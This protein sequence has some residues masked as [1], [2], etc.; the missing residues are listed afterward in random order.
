[1]PVCRFEKDWTYRGLPCL[2]IENSYLRVLLFPQLGGHI[3]R[4]VDK[5]RDRNVLWESPRVRLH[6]TELHSNFDDHWSG[7]W[8][9]IFPNGMPMTNSSGDALPGMGELWN[10]EC[11]WQVVEASKQRVEVMLRMRTPISAVEVQRS[12]AVSV[13]EPVV[14]VSYRLSN[15][16]ASPV[17]YL[18][19]VH[20]ALDVTTAHRFDIP[21][22]HAEVGGESSGVPLGTPGETYRWPLLHGTDLSRPLPWQS[23]SYALHYLT[24]LTEGWAA[25]TCT[26]ERAGV[27]FVFDVDAFPFVGL[28]MVYGGWRG[29]YHAIMEPFTGYPTDLAAADHAGHT[30]HLDAGVPAQLDLTAVLYWG[31]DG[32]ASLASDGSVVG[33]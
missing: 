17:P 1:M 7:G 6:R 16:G 9:D 22:R 32:V 29:Y 25:C 24:E 19:G 30:R 18:Y 33:V 14:N 15:L 31:V 20:P 21:A 10:A 11:D 4:L 23:Q 27:G 28:W 8:D 5:R 3:S 12:Y 13:D 2:Q 26:K